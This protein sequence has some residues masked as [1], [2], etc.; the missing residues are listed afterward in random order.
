MQHTRRS[1]TI[2]GFAL[3]ILMGGGG[4]SN[5]QEGLL[6]EFQV[7]T[8]TAS[9]LSF[10]TLPRAAVSP[11]GDFIVVW[12]DNDQVEPFVSG[13]RFGSDGN[14]LSDQFQINSTTGVFVAF[15]DVAVAPNG[16]AFVVWSRFQTTQ[17]DVLGQRLTASGALLGSEFVIADE[18]D[19]ATGAV[20]A[21]SP[22]GE[23]M[24]AWGSG[25][26]P[27]SDTSGASVQARRFDASGGAVG[28][29]FQV[30]TT[31][32][33][34]QGSPEISIG[35][36]GTGVVIWFDQDPDLIRGQRYA[37]SGSPVGQE[38]S[39][40]PPLGVTS[41]HFVAH[42]PNGQFVAIWR[43]LTPGGIETHG[44]RFDTAGNPIAS[45]QFEELG[46]GFAFAIDPAGEIVF[47]SAD[48][49]FDD[50]NLL[51]STIEARR[52]DT[53]GTAVG[54]AFQVRA[55]TSEE[56]ES[57]TIAIDDAG[58]L[59]IAWHGVTNA[60]ILARRTGT[61][62]LPALGA[63]GLLFL[64]AAALVAGMRSVQRSRKLDSN[65]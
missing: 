9:V 39:I 14:P 58:R 26:S 40:S 57:P 5:A 37:A 22:T 8:A 38:F 24:V 63:N 41:S 28:S 45:F 59:L 56:H 19:F 10:G 6:P 11:G 21:V 54:S 15:A 35:P 23:A 20:V 3:A 13:R 47:V 25:S 2:A 34:F 17:F 7:N 36:D 32:T 51:G 12:N 30:N 46:A 48:T 64:A 49:Q 44:Q 62:N 27:G 50:G 31:T 53:T 43:I 65:S 16:V 42:D 4:A 61:V 60:Q 55:Y 1:S 52:Y 33:G 18:P 29:R